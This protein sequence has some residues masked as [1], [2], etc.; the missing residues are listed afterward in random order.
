MKD[1]QFYLAKVQTK[2][3]DD[4]GK[5][6]KSTEQYLVNAVNPTDVEVIVTKEFANVSFEW[7]ITSITASKIISVLE[8]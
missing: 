3:E 7:E 1:T 2:Q 6:K 5:I 8:K 4:K